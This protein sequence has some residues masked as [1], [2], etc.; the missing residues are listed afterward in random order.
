MLDDFCGLCAEDPEKIFNLINGARQVLLIACHSRAVKLLLQNAGVVE[1]E[2]IRFFNLLEEDHSKLVS[3]IEEFAGHDPQV[4]PAPGLPERVG[5]ALGDNIPGQS[6]TLL[7]Q[8]DP[9]W[10]AWYPVIDYS[11]C[12]HCGQCADFCLFGVYRKSTDRI[13]VVNPAYCKDNCPAC[14]R[15]CPEIAIVFPKYAGEGAIGGS[16]TIDDRLEMQRLQ[17]DTEAILG[18]DI[19]KALEQRKSKRRLII[20]EDLMQK[21][22][23]ER[24]KAMEQ[25]GVDRKI[26]VPKNNP[27]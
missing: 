27:K 6:S 7:Q 21:A 26:Q 9:S 10:S 24:D 23:L 17:R 22:I 12:N 3:A 11:R 25:T 15:I 8:S 18:D 16:D 1:M 13:E 5:E 20:R 2:K 14:A 19:Y 4:N